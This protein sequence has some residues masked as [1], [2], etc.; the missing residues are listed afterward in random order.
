LQWA[1]RYTATA[2]LL[3]WAIAAAILSMFV[4]GIWMIYFK[5]ADGAL[6]H[7]LYNLHESLGVT[8]LLLVPLRVIV[9]IRRPPPPLPASM[10]ATVRLAAAFNHL[11]LYALLLVMP[12]IGFLSNNTR[13]VPLVWFE[14]VRLP[15]ALT[16][17]DGAAHA[18]S[19]LHWAGALT[20][21]ALIGAHLSGAAYH[22]LIR[23]DDVLQRML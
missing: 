6:R 9:R 1:G 4:L 12:V 5:P 14:L 21:F 20:L 23:H 18:L 15:S 8:I 3:H 16:K 19:A 13:G 17:D 22:A 10:P 7:R 11:A 2:R